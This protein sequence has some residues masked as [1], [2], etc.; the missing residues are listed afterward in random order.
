MT[1]QSTRVAPVA[2]TTIP[3]WILDRRTR[4]ELQEEIERVGYLTCTWCESPIDGPTGVTVGG[5]PV[6]ESVCQRP[7][8]WEQVPA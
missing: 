2:K 5:A 3:D 8:H 4:R 6:C 7:R 1:G